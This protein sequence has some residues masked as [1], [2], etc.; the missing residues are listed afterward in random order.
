MRVLPHLNDKLLEIAHRVPHAFTTGALLKPLERAITK[1][2][3]FY[4]IPHS[5]KHPVV[6]NRLLDMARGKIVFED[7]GH[8][9]LG[10]QYVLDDEAIRVL[11]IKNR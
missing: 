6:S 10:L 11:R 3:H 2:A 4:D 5:Q 9:L 8:L 7:L 1:S